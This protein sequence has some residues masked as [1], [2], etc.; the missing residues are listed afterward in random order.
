MK[1]LL[2]ESIEDGL[3][4]IILLSHGAFAMALLQTSKMLYDDDRNLSCFCL[5]DEDDPADLREAVIAELTRMP[6]GSIVL[7]DLFAGTPYNQMAYAQMKGHQI[8]GLTG[9]N[10]PV[11]LEALTLR[12]ECGGAELIHQLMDAGKQSFIALG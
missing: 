7:L 8:N 2:S 4:G 3:P 10:L 11:L 12:T 1:V 5:E 6:E 9:A